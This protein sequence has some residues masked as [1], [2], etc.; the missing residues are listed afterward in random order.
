MCDMAENNAKK[1]VIDMLE[2]LSND[3]K[4]VQNAPRDNEEKPRSIR[5]FK[6]AT[7]SA[8]NNEGST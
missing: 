5:T 4:R 8:E 2:N 3:I 7:H 6:H 1:N